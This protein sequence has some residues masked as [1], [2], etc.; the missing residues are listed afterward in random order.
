MRASLVEALLISGLGGLAGIGVAHWGTSM[1]TAFWPDDFMRN[2]SAGLLV[3]D[4][5]AMAV[6]VWTLAFALLVVLGTT[7]LVG[8]IPA[9]RASAAEPSTHLK[10]GSGGT[11]KSSSYFGIDAGSALVGLQVSLALVLLFAASLMG[12][13]VRKLLA[14]DEGFRSENLLTFDFSQ[15]QGV[16]S[17]SRY[18][19]TDE[20]EARVAAK[21]SFDEALRRRITALPGV[22]GMTVGCRLLQEWACGRV[23]VTSVEGQPAH[24]PPPVGLVIVGEGYFE[25][26]EIP[27]IQGRVLT[28]EDGLDGEPVVVLS[29][30]AASTFFPREDPVGKQ[31][32]FS[33]GAPE[34]QTMRVVGVVGEV[35]HMSIDQDPVPVAYFSSRELGGGGHVIVRTTVNPSR[36]LR[37][38]Q[39][40]VKEVDPTVAMSNVA[41]VAEIVGRGIADRRMI[42]TL[43]A[44]ISTIT[45]LLVVVGTWSVVAN[46]VVDR[47]RELG[48]RL[49]VGA[50]HRSVVMLVLNSVLSAAGV[51]IAIGL[52]GALLGTSLIQTFLWQVDS[53]DPSSLAGSVAVLAA[54]VI[55]AGYLPA[56]SAS[57]IGLDSTLR[58]E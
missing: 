56:R 48:I 28:S 54:I 52:V 2:P 17:V 9:L 20:W 21:T 49:A 16:E 13:S 18:I 55:A 46:S 37:A 5:G 25:L 39:E 12:T 33:Y 1:I 8:M 15:P 58:A 24:E 19:S 41:T 57:R 10:A 3:G 23:G 51:G 40:T 38:I 26:M 6:D 35:R 27:V 42:L 29:E 4:L 53:W 45:L 36:V 7:I 50:R 22:E 32:G 30:L 31:I 43:L 34:R 44:M 14:V 47:R 11:R